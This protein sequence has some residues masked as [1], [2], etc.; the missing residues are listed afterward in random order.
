MVEIGIA[1]VGVVEDVV[2]EVTVADE[3]V[4]VGVVQAMEE[5]HASSAIKKDTFPENVPILVVA[6]EEAAE[7]ATSAMKPDTFL[8]TAL[9]EVVIITA[10]SVTSRAIFQGT[11]PREEVGVT[12]TSVMS[13]GIFQGT[14]HKEEVVVAVTALNAMNLVI[15]QGTARKAEAVDLEVVVGVAEEVVEGVV[16]HEGLVEEVV[17]T[18]TAVVSMRTLHLKIRKF[19]L[20]RN[21]T[22]Y[23]IIV[24][25]F[26]SD[27]L[28][29][30]LIK[31]IAL[32]LF[33]LFLITKFLT[34]NFLARS[35]RIV[36]G[37]SQRR[38]QGY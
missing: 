17:Q 26:L 31:F 29:S 20:I 11:V 23:L 34:L 2:A 18:G 36:G 14:A 9:K 8:A 19:H 13:L 16:A 24:V 35:Q 1:L 15:Y 6:V 4:A 27:S 33:Q 25:L 12:V 28:F 22:V 32:S 7:I 21:L 10:S 5:V 3:E 37:E 38:P 30:Y